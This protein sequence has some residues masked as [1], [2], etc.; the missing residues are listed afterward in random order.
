MK[1]Q[2][3]KNTLIN[4][5]LEEHFLPSLDVG[6]H[7]P[8]M[9]RIPGLPFSAWV[10]L[11]FSITKSRDYKKEFEENVVI[12]AK[13][14]MKMITSLGIYVPPRDPAYL[15]RW[16][17]RV[18]YTNPNTRYLRDYLKHCKNRNLDPTVISQLSAKEWRNWKTSLALSFARPNAVER[19][20]KGYDYCKDTDPN[21]LLLPRPNMWYWGKYV[22]IYP[23]KHWYSLCFVPTDDIQDLGPHLVG[24]LSVLK[25]M[26]AVIVSHVVMYMASL[27]KFFNGEKK[28]YKPLI[29][30]LMQNVMELTLHD[31]LQP[32]YQLPRPQ[33]HKFT[34][35]WLIDKLKVR[36]T[37]SPTNML[38][39]KKIFQALRQFDILVS[40]NGWDPLKSNAIEEAHKI[41]SAKLYQ[42]VKDNNFAM[43]AA[44]T[45]KMN[46]RDFERAQNLWLR[47]T[48]D[49]N[50]QSVPAPGGKDGITVNGFTLVQLDKKDPKTFFI[51]D[52]TGCCQ[53]FGGA[54]ESSMRYSV[55]K[56]NSAVWVV[57][58][59]ETILAQSFVW[60]NENVLILDNIEAM[61][62]EKYVPEIK[63][64]FMEGVK[65]T[66][67]KFG[68]TEIYQGA[69][70]ND[71]VL[72]D[73]LY[74]TCVINQHTRVLDINTYT[75]ARNIFRVAP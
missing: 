54:G 8:D 51:G 32:F 19:L 68:I 6:V 12:I 48:A 7:I 17:A 53:T 5:G 14:I 23:R 59:G 64:V 42:N 27:A 33:N 44:A 47:L 65:S 46:E 56:S 18:A 21:A 20:P 28:V 69:T 11:Y 36:N 39:T 75:D 62:H 52:Y 22:G 24:A 25:S 61:G 63:N 72:H 10:D 1:K 66:L 29:P 71:I 31:A 3:N 30:M 37:Q 38:E 13:R 57:K 73:D 55:S 2:L 34:N 35:K 67:G 60:Q 41:I 9:Y 45:G 49:L 15:I 50:Y 70:S 43:E 40:E 58:K 74:P 4:E 16:V 26:D